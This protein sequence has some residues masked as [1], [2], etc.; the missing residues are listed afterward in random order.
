MIPA[1]TNLRRSLGIGGPV[2]ASEED[3]GYGGLAAFVDYLRG[4]MTA[5]GVRITPDRVHSIPTP[6]AC[7]RILSEALARIPLITYRRLPDGGKERAKDHPYYRL[8]KVRANG[9]QSAAE[10]RSLMATD[11]ET[12]GNAYALKVDV[13]GE[14]RDLVRL[15]PRRV[16]KKRSAAGEVSYQVMDEAGVRLVRTYSAGSILHLR[17]P[18]GTDLVA[19]A[20]SEQYQ[21]LFGLAYAVEYFLSSSFRNGIRPSVAFAKETG[22]LTDKS[23]AN[24]KEWIREYQGSGA[25]SKAILLEDGV[26]PV[27]F[28]TNNEQGQVAELS[29][30]VDLKVVRVYTL[31]PHMVAFNV[32]QPRANM[33]QQARE[34]IEQALSSRTERWEQRLNLDLF[35]GGEDEYFCEFLFEDL[36][37]GDPAVRAAFYRTMVEIGAMTSNEVRTRENLNPLEGGDTIVTPKNLDRGPAPPP[38]R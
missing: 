24:L 14:V 13:A 21:E 12:F 30:K 37:K 25:A 7:I 36:L 38:P 34:F 15:D 9:E 17:G 23:R 8:L 3:A 32:A 11:I 20:P 18:F 1:I 22:L 5:A 4:A 2:K 35:D 31:P 6:A 16:E 27:P 26:K 29:D 10:W 19:K 28:G 33:E